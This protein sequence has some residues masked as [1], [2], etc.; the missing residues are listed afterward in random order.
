MSPTTTC[1]RRERGYRWEK[2]IVDIFNEGGDWKARRLGGSS[3]GLPDI[4]ITNNEKS[5]I[6]SVE[7]K[8][9]VG[10]TAYIPNDQI[11]R[12]LDILDMFSIYRKKSVVFAFKFAKSKY[13]PEL[14][15]YL[16]RIL[17]NRNMRDIKTLKCN[18]DG[19]LSLIRMIPD[20]DIGFSYFF[21]ESLKDLKT[22]HNMNYLDRI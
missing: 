17:P 18:S 6:Y 19:R 8:S 9:T 11:C 22:Y 10:K 16:F 2:T 4:V 1:H 21:T 13:N 20:D 7:A 15:Y 5:T 3:V 14:K 12:C